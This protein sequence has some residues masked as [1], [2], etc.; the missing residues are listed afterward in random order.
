MND[1]QSPKS[2]YH[3]PTFCIYGNLADLTKNGGTGTITENNGKPNMS[4]V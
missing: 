4:R 2:R 1:N 3:Q